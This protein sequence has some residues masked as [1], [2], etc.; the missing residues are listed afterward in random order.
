[1]LAPAGS[2]ESMQAAFLAGA[3]AVYAGGSLFGARA[4]ADNFTEEELLRAIDYG[5]LHGKKLY[6]TLNTL[7]KK[8][9]IEEQLYSFLRPLYE[10]GL[11]GVILQDMGVLSFVREAFPALPVH[12]STQ[13]TV[14]GVDGARFLEKQGVKRI[15][16]ARELSLE[17]LGAIKK[18]CS[19]ELE[20]FVHGALCYCYSG[21]C[22]FSSLL[23]GRSGNRG[24]CAQPCR[25][26]YQL[27]GKKLHYLSPKDLCA[28]NI[29]PALFEAGMDSFKI[30]GR[31]KNARYTG[32]VVSV[33]RKYM[34][35]YRE[36]PE[37]YQ[38]NPEDL[39]FLMELY[40]RGYMTEGYFFRHNAGSMMSPKRTNHYGRYLG[41]A[42]ISG[43][44]ASFVS[45]IPLCRGD[46]LEFRDLEEQI[47]ALHTVSKEEEAAGALQVKLKKAA[48]GYK[49]ISVYRT[50]YEGLSQE[51]QERM[52][53]MPKRILH[54][55][56]CLEA[57]KPAALTL[58][59]ENGLQVSA[60]YGEAM[61]AR[62]RPLTEE[63]VCRQIKRTGGTEFEIADLACEIKGNLFLPKQALN[64]LRRE[65][66]SAYQEQLFKGFRRNA[67]RDG[68]L[69]L[70]KAAE[71]TGEGVF[72]QGEDPAGNGCKEYCLAASVETEEQ[73]QALLDCEEISR[74]DLDAGLFALGQ[75]QGWK[76]MERAFCEVRRRKKQVFFRMPAVFRQRSRILYEKRFSALVE[77]T[78]G[79]VVRNIDEYAFV[80][81]RLET[82]KKDRAVL[83]DFTV[84]AFQ[85]EAAKFWRQ[86]G[87]MLTA[88]IE[89]NAGELRANRGCYDE[90]VV[91]GRYPM[92]V[93]AGC[94]YQTDGYM[95]EG[96]DV[97][98]GKGCKTCPN[99]LYLTDRFQKKFPVK[100][101]CGACYNVIYNSLPLSLADSRQEIDGLGIST[102]R[103]LFTTESARET[104]AA[105]EAFG[106]VFLGINNKN[107]DYLLS[108]TFTRGHFKRGVE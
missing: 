7:L 88:P 11:D 87:C 93:S 39:A 96:R 79:F 13:M 27:N 16:P 73:L 70:E 19:L 105:A 30:E 64:A 95:R 17:E 82:L 6:L 33:Y 41:R 58:E 74:L 68:I 47:L 20:V 54:G 59:D 43:N 85:P 23:G 22:F 92:M 4:Y 1:M 103:L 48:S 36:N 5:H 50:K 56:L 71:G 53:E 76:D 3:D 101:F 69:P 106:S 18:A 31:M 37:A 9:E 102:L 63:E 80:T 52:P 25:L 46:V 49:E 65:A 38:V 45:G 40:N 72:P 28:L 81:E 78:D 90:L 99:M 26:L 42:K 107:T 91:Y 62:T 55:K 84:Y 100:L 77:I 12:G 15:V 61:P 67:K 24:K 32:G 108:D 97:C 66:L 98:A 35:Q 94:L 83:C 8:Q 29:L 51:L 21:Q 57:G 86:R 34:D 89:L 10:A 44:R 2:Y 14:T 75:E 60:K 104:K